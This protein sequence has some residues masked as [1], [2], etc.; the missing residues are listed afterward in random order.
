MHVATLV[1]EAKGRP[2][3]VVAYDS[4]ALAGDVKLPARDDATSNV[5][6]K[7]ANRLAHQGTP[8][9]KP[10]SEAEQILIAKY[11]GLLR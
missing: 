7:L 6:S 1:L 9:E 10:L 2:R 11:A 8:F 3:Y 4:A 5:I